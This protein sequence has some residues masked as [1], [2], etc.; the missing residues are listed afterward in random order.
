MQIQRRIFLKKTGSAVACA[1]LGC[2]GIV[3]SADKYMAGPAGQGRVEDSKLIIDLNKNPK[4]K[5]VGGWANFDVGDKKVVVLHP[6]EPDYKAFLNKCTH[7][8]GQLSY[9]HKDGFTQ[10]ALHG[11]RFDTAGRVVKGPAT[12]PITE[13]RTNLDK[14]QLI[15]Y[16]S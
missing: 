6:A 1:C 5:E 4:L 16:L 3:E 14:D 10:C 7:Q 9:R 8:G 2:A 15:V 11:S 13:F 12:L